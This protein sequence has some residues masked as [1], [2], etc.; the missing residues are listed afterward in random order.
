MLKSL[1]VNS[2]SSSAD[3][4]FLFR[5]APQFHCAVCMCFSFNGFHGTS[6]S[7][8]GHLGRGRLLFSRITTVSLTCW[9]HRCTL[10]AVRFGAQPLHP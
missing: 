8:R 1:A 4:R 10:I 3:N 2:F 9:F 7:N 6:M 5:S